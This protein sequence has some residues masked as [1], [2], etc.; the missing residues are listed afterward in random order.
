MLLYLVWD[1]TG[2]WTVL[3]RNPP[4]PPAADGVL[5][6]RLLGR[7]DGVEEG[8]EAVESLNTWLA[9]AD[10]ARVRPSR[11]RGNEDWAFERRRLR[12]G[13]RARLRD[14]WPRRDDS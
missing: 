10:L 3:L 9:A 8:L 2:F 13:K 12:P 14:S 11:A 1:A 6:L 7:V 5:H 4:S